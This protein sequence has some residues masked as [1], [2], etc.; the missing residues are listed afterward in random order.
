MGAMLMSAI[1]HFELRFGRNGNKLVPSYARLP[2]PFV[3]LM[4]VETALDANWRAFALAIE[5]GF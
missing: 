1:K 2:L 5:I 3:G 4:A